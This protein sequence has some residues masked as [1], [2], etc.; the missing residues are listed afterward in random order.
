VARSA[1]S[2]PVGADFGYGGHATPGNAIFPIRFR[3]HFSFTHVV[4]E[5]ALQI[6]VTM[7]GKG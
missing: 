6:S 2:S 4:T 5:S 3:K 7:K 1:L